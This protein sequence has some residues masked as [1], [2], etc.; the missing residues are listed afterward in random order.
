VTQPGASPPLMFELNGSPEHSYELYHRGA[1]K[2]TGRPRT[3]NRRSCCS[4]ALLQV[5]KHSRTRPHPYRDVSK[6]ARTRGRMTSVSAG[7]RRF[8]GP[9]GIESL[10][11]EGRFSGHA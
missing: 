4:D 10:H 8:G 2:H 5:S 6:S 1:A 3:R 11:V 9:G 7:E